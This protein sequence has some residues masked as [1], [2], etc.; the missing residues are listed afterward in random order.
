MSELVLFGPPGAGKGTQAKRLVDDFGYY[1]LST[2][3]M[4]RAERKSGSELGKK[5]DEYMSQ[6]QLVPIEL[7]LDLVE[8]GI[9][10]AGDKAVLFDG[11]PRSVPQAEALD[12]RLEKLGRKI[13]H[14]VSMEVALE[15]ILDRVAGRRVCEECGQ[16]YHVRYDAPP[17]DGT[18][19]ACG[20]KRVI[21]RKDD[22]EEVVSRRYAEYKSTT[23]PVLPYYRA[24]GLV[25]AINGLGTLDEVFN[26]IKGA[27]GR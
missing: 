23:E 18:C 12:A 17:S 22:S 9:A 8:Q 13:G 3:D 11:F 15:D 27:I 16:T 7:V 20:Q 14:V 10:A 25:T 1:Q 19:R 24:K 5:F 26:R 2:G 21:Q 6:G 4:M